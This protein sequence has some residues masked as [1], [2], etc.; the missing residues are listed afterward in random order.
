MKNAVSLSSKEST[1]STFQVASRLGVS[2]CTVQNWVE[3]GL[4]KAWKTPGGHRRID[5]RVV[6][7]FVEKKQN[8]IQCQQP[9]FRILLINFEDSMA[10]EISSLSD[11]GKLEMTIYRET[12]IFR[13]L[14]SIGHLKPKIVIID[15]DKQEPMI[16]EITKVCDRAE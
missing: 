6:D 13:G 1:F 15:M 3:R 2:V 5:A 7:A 10:E 9:I 12:G 8:S 4:L 16:T 11:R 14:L